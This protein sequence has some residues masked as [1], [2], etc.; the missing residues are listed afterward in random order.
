MKQ[1][2]SDLLYHGKN[3]N[4]NNPNCSNWL[5]VL[6]LICFGK[7]S[8]NGSFTAAD[9]QGEEGSTSLVYI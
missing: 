3:S 4:Q 6:I 9:L 2:E 8:Q 7:L 5:I 1:N